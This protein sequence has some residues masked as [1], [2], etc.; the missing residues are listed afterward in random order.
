MHCV[1][2]EFAAISTMAVQNLDLKNDK[3]SNPIFYLFAFY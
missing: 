1:C 2:F 3:I